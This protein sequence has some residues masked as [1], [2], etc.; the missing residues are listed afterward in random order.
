M[1]FPTQEDLQE[2]FEEVNGHIHSPVKGFFTKY[3]AERTMA[4][5]WP[6]LEESTQIQG[7]LTPGVKNPRVFQTFCQVFDGDRV[8]KFV[9]Y[10]DHTQSTMRCH[11]VCK[12]VLLQRGKYAMEDVNVV[13]IFQHTGTAYG[14]GFL[15]LCLAAS[16]AF[17]NTPSRLFLHGF[18]IFGSRIQ[19]WVFDRTGLYG[20][21]CF[22]MHEE[23]ERMVSIFNH[24]ANMSDV[25]VGVNPLVHKDNTAW[26]V[27]LQSDQDDENPETA[28][29]LYLDGDPIADPDQIASR[30]P[31]CYR[32][33]RHGVKESDCVVKMAW[34]SPSRRRPE[35]HMLQLAK[36]RKVSGLVQLISS[37]HVVT[38]SDL[39]QG[40]EIE[41]SKYFAE[42]SDLDTGKC[43]AGYSYY[44]D[45]K[46]SCVVTAPLG[47]PL[48][49]YRSVPEFL[50]AFCDAIEGHKSLYLDGN[51][52][53][54]DVS[55]GNIIIL[56]KTKEKQQRGMLIDLDLAVDMATDSAA[57]AQGAGTQP[58]IAI[59]VLNGEPHTY[60]HDLESFLY[61]FIEIAICEGQPS[62]LSPQ[63]PLNGWAVKSVA[64]CARNKTR[65]MRDHFRAILGE[66][67]PKFQHL[68]VVAVEMRDALFFPSHAGGSFFTG[69]SHDRKDV[70]ALYH[71]MTHSTRAVLGLMKMQ[72]MY[73][74]LPSPNGPSSS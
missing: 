47:Y 63:S 43:W 38:I 65:H 73:S 66:F 28:T 1:P 26:Y 44:E 25:Q 24:Y 29:R 39:H 33:R 71:K 23:P 31:I 17:L 59:G 27:T 37:C 61:L 69:T 49:E 36:E 30:G 12:S 22:E 32:A 53:H 8:F 9:R 46:L 51:I 67:S 6:S 18:H 50:E 54:R 10:Q 11:L 4:S 20:S 7:F 19:F 35:E 45:L 42:M 60:R 58:Y 40:L 21:E 56:E 34:R 2:V 57:L 13:G 64:T 52:L 68:G 72:I 55:A 48:E 14:Q 62:K 74:Q 16:E 5:F 15:H 3:F 70:E 41:T